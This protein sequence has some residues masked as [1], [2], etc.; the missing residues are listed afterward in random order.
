[1]E[2][3]RKRARLE[4]A[5][6]RFP[7]RVASFSPVWCSGLDAR[8]EEPAFF[9]S[10]PLLK[11]TK[12]TVGNAS[13]VLSV[14]NTKTMERLVVVNDLSRGYLHACTNALGIIQ[15]FSQKCLKE[16]V[17]S[18]ALT[19]GPV[20]MVQIK[21]DLLRAMHDV[22]WM[23]LNLTR[24][25][26]DFMDGCTEFLVNILETFKDFEVLASQSSA[27]SDLKGVARASLYLSRL[28]RWAFTDHS[29]AV[30]LPEDS[31]VSVQPVESPVES[32]IDS[33]YAA[34]EEEG[35]IYS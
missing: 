8:N 4:E 22:D 31:S 25:I 24:E 21:E 5:Q 27:G 7:L 33:A 28:R 12:A 32:E 15:A 16:G 11:L 19:D 20:A 3:F 14:P 13:V 9:N 6:L 26:G 1:M 29:S 10:R 30:P 34:E 35:G 18:W 17:A 23:G 2:S